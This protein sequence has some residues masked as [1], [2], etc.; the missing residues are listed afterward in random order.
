MSRLRKISILG[1]TGSIGGNTLK[2][3][4]ANPSLYD[5]VALATGSDWKTMVRQARQFEPEMVALF[6]EEAAQKAMDSL[7]GSGI[8][9]AVGMEGLLEAASMEDADTVVSAIVGSAGVLPTYAA[10]KAGKVIALANKEALVAAGHLICAQARESGAALIPIDSEH[11]AVFQV[12]LGQERTAVRKVILTA[13]GGPFFGK[14]RDFLSQVTPGMALEHPRWKMGPKVTVDSATMMNKGLEV[15]EA[16]W[17]FDLPPEKIEV[18]VHPQ[19]VVHSMV[20]FMDGSVLAQ[21]GLADMRIPISFALSYPERV[22][23]GIPA[24]DLTAVGPLEFFS[25]EKDN[26]PC[27]DLAYRALR[28]GTAMPVVMNAANEVA[29]RAFLDGVLG[30]T[31]I[32]E[33]VKSVMESFSPFDDQTIVGILEG[34][35]IARES[36]RALL[37]QAGEAQ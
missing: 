25:P 20:E 17:L 27:L 37:R 31:E 22:D 16:R 5:I 3:V 13:S 24:L 23:L 34:D 14:P 4:D 7:K 12:L 28:E 18:L 2:V 21:M 26:F 33:V 35:R 36:A 10:A 29:V 19:S 6:N 1:S 15:L 11:S 8:R 9:V 30:F 32:P